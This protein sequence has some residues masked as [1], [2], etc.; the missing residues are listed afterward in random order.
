MSV[1]YQQ[2]VSDLQNIIRTHA[3]YN[4]LPEMSLI[5]TTIREEMATLF[6]PDLNSGLVSL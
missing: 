5:I 3:F 2:V 6:P 1:W 4:K